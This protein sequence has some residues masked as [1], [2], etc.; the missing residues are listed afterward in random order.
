VTW[1]EFSGVGTYYYTY[2]MQYYGRPAWGPYPVEPPVSESNSVSRVIR[3]SDSPL[4]GY[5]FTSDSSRTGSSS[6]YNLPGFIKEY[7]PCGFRFPGEL[8]RGFAYVMPPNFTFDGQPVCSYYPE[9]PQAQDTNPL[10]GVITYFRCGNQIYWPSFSESTGLS[11]QQSIRC[12]ERLPLENL[13]LPVDSISTDPVA[14]RLF[15][16]VSPPPW[17][18]GEL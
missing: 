10:L 17:Y 9:K 4:G 8:T 5:C 1:N 2:Q 13:V 12:I 3:R 18:S 7:S 15:G 11:R 14:R 6:G 16:D